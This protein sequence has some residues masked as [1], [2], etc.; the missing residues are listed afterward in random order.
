[1]NDGTTQTTE[2]DIKDLLCFILKHIIVLV[3][4]S[5]IF[6]GVGAGY[7]LYKQANTTPTSNVLDI[8]VKL[9]GESEEAYANRVA[10][11]ERVISIKNNISAITRQVEIQNDY[12][13]SSIYMQ[14]DPLNTATTKTQL[15]IS[16]DNSNVGVLETLYNAYKED[17][18]RGDY[19]TDV[20]DT[21]GYSVGATQE[22]ITLDFK[23]SELSSSDSLNQMGIMTICVVG[24]SFEKTDLI[25]DAII[26]EIE[27]RS[28]DF[29][30]S[31]ASHSISFVGRQSSVGFDSIVRQKQL[32]SVTTLN[33][34]QTQINNLNNNL[35]SIAKNLGLK[36]KTSFYEPVTPLGVESS[37]SIKNL[38]LYCILG[39]AAG[40]VLV[41]GAL[42]YVYV[43]GKTILSQ[44]QFFALFGLEKIGVCKPL[45]R[46]SKFQ[47]ILDRWSNDD[48]SLSEDASRAIIEANFEN[49]T[50]GVKRVLVTGTV[51]SD[52]VKESIKRLN[53]KADVKMDMFSDP[54]VIKTASEYD[55]IVLVEQRGVSQRKAINEQI[56]LL[57][58]SGTIIIGAIVL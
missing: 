37:I 48:T 32:D 29:M 3:I 44:T 8:S 1:M 2:I 11:V 10:N 13:S 28:D 42:S 39:F 36:D 55:G 40:I 34:M 26:A 38:L 47:I 17:I 19:I 51:D 25:M 58:N 7:S 18:T 43:L 6:A 27:T 41:G 50:R 22:L 54:S 21:L 49:M 56:R 45:N 53:I 20:A 16:C 15:V 52:V 5:A 35:D 46:K 14:I 4:V 31:I 12:L 33:T 57:K 24:E 30:S 9:P 23:T